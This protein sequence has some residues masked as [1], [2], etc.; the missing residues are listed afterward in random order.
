MKRVACFILLLW[1][2][3][4]AQNQATIMTYNLL[5][6]NTATDRNSYFRTVTAAADPDILVVQEILSINGVNNF[7][8]NV[9]NYA[10]ST[11]SAGTFIDGTDTD[12]AIF[13]KPVLFSFISNTPIHTALRDINEF[14]LVYNSTNDTLRIYSVHLKASTGSQNEQQR[15]A[16]VN[17]L[18]QVTDNLTTESDF[19][20]V[21][22]FNIYTAS[23]PA[24]QALL[25]Q[26]SPGYFL[27]PINSPGNW[28]N[29][30][31]F[32]SIHTQSPRVRQFGGGSS[33]GMDDRFDLILAS[34]SVINSGGVDYITNT[35][36]AF[37]NDGA[38]FNDSINALPNTAVPPNV[39]N[40]LH[41]ASDHL[42]VLMTLKFETL[43]GIS[44]NLKVF[45]Q[46]PYDAGTMH[47]L[48]D[49]QHLLPARQPYSRAPWNYN[50]SENVAGIPPEIVDWVLVELRTNTN[51]ESKVATRAAFLKS[52]GSIVDMDGN[53]PLR[54]A[55]AP[56]NYY[57]V[58][59]HRNH[60]SIMSAAA[61][62]LT[63]STPLYDFTTAQSKAYGNMPQKQLGSGLYGMYAGD[64]NA[65][66]IIGSTDRNSAWRSQN[67][68]AWDYSKYGDF[69][70]DAGIDALDLNRCWRPND[71]HTTQV[72]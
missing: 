8:N 28:H 23:E 22:D 53:S 52:D 61:Q 17:L 62:L 65:D 57:I 12:N 14:K 70:L 18:R 47:A 7:L 20:V 25:S 11:Y 43:L 21:G 64:G 56:G 30:A 42:P 63:E 15:L 66:G 16:E 26:A 32:A 1:S 2:L 13:Y 38:H 54:F 69:N 29:N 41:Y 46:G 48:L 72:P 10:G 60:L 19:M 55:V 24:Y 39:A 40:A 45:L 27:D 3:V 71:G 51:A 36:S 67:G 33:G 31:S 59:H 37:G 5:N 6:Y 50:G 49:E 35:Y 34:Q 4:F 58:V 68:T 44:L 9:L